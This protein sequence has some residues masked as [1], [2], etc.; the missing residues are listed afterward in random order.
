[1]P[2]KAT[3]S[4]PRPQSPRARPA[5]ARRPARN[6]AQHV[7]ATARTTDQGARLAWTIGGGLAALIVILVAIGWYNDN[8]GPGRETAI[9]VGK[10][11]LSLAYYRDRLKAQAVENGDGSQTDAAR[12]LS[13]VTQTLEEEQVYLQRAW[14]LGVTASDQ[15]IAAQIAQIVHVPVQNGKIIDAAQYDF[16]VRAY[17]ERTGLSLDEL[18]EIARAEVLQQK[19]VDHFQATLPT[20]ALAIQGIQFVFDSLDKAQAAQKELETGATIYDLQSELNQDASKGSASPLDWTYVGFGVLPRPIDVAA[21]QLQ[22]GEVST[23]IEVP[24]DPT[25][26]TS[27]SQWEMLAVTNKDP[28]HPITDSAKSQLARSEASLWF[29]QQKTALGVHSLLDLNKER[30]AVQHT[31][32]PLQPPPTPTP[33]ASAPSAPAINPAVPGGQAGPQ[34]PA[35]SAPA[36]PNATP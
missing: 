30:W 16:E 28:N 33:P 23:I 1:V 9:R 12:Q 25:D 20:Q 36:A 26:P 17:L 19:V 6:V 13:T 5:P 35:P 34:P 18:R 21:Q 14:A 8:I 24:A 32:L 7:R 3:S 11:N 4:T 10:H 15:E 29:N 22:P 31:G 27:K 2:D